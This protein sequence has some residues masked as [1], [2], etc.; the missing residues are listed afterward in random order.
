LLFQALESR[1]QLLRDRLVVP[2]QT[3]RSRS[4]LEAIRENDS[5]RVRSVR[6]CEYFHIV[7]M[8]PLIGKEPFPGIPD[9]IQGRVRL[10]F[11]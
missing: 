1:R 10:S 6:Q 3:F 7:H 2:V 9:V 8:K 4:I 11:G 5:R